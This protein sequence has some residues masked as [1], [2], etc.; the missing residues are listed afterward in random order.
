MLILAGAPSPD[1][2][3]GGRGASALEVSV[4]II[5]TLVYDARAFM[6]GNMTM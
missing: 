1:T 5:A 4:C 3:L 2:A 6:T